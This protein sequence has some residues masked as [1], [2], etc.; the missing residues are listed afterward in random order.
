MTRT[1][2]RWPWR[3]LRPLRGARQGQ[4][5]RVRVIYGVITPSDDPPCKSP[6]FRLKSNQLPHAPQRW[7]MNAPVFLLIY[8]LI[9]Q[10]M[11]P[12]TVCKDCRSCCNA[13]WGKT[14]TPGSCTLPRSPC[15]GTPCAECTREWNSR[16]STVN[17]LHYSHL[18]MGRN[19]GRCGIGRARQR[20]RLGK[21]RGS[22]GRVATQRRCPQLRLT[23]SQCQNAQIGQERLSR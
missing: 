6:C 4:R 12:P 2:S 21:G 9:K 22:T 7:Q 8:L 18:V 3:A 10:S 17:R 14:C 15:I 19:E 11:Q 20:N 13:V 1:R 16:R 5:L 23:R